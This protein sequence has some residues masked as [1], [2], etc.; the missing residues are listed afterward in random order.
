MGLQ[1][2]FETEL[3]FQQTLL[4]LT[5]PERMLLE[6]TELLLRSGIHRSKFSSWPETPS[7]YVAV[8][9]LTSLLLACGLNPIRGA[10]AEPLKPVLQSYHLKA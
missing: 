10:I 7:K 5:E 8:C 1:S 3:I 6:A 2:A 4:H 9:I